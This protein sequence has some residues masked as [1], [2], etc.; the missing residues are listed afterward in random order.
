MYSLP[1]EVTEDCRAGNKVQ[2]KA[3]F[4]QGHSYGFGSELFLIV[5]TG[6]KPAGI[7]VVPSHIA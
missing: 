2:R 6:N 3:Y 7:L 1:K 4:P 5:S